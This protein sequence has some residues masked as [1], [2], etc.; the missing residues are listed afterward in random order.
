VNDFIVYVEYGD[1]GLPFQNFI[2]LDC[3]RAESQEEAFKK[4]SK[5]KKDR[6]VRIMPLSEW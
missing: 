3:I 5:K 4:F 2:I 1:Y 6:N